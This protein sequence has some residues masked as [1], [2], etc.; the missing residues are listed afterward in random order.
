[1]SF[2]H[3]RFRSTFPIL[4]GVVLA[5]LPLFA[6]PRRAAVDPL[7]ASTLMPHDFYSA[8]FTN[9]A[10]A[11]LI[12]SSIPSASDAPQG[13][14]ESKLWYDL[15]NSLGIAPA[16][17]GPAMETDAGVELEAISQLS[18]TGMPTHSAFLLL[19]TGLVLI[20]AGKRLG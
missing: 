3:R 20:W 11:Y 4:L 8:T 2:S 10:G 15:T 19:G 16:N 12:P 13:A 7:P 9:P 17:T 6:S 5:G 14:T 1:M 18:V